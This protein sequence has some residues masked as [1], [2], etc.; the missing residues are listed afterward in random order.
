[1]TLKYTDLKES[2]FNLLELQNFIKSMDPEYIQSITSQKN[3]LDV[4]INK[5]YQH[6]EINLVFYPNKIIGFIAT[7]CNDLNTK[8]AFIT[9][10]CILNHY[11]RKGI[12]TKLIQNAEVQAKKCNMQSIS[13]EVS[14]HNLGAISFYKKH[15]FYEQKVSKTETILMTKRI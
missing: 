12:G 6:S 14:K 13:L 15:G 7:Y 11:R 5:L 4:Y 8:I 9:S 10:I 1:M 3:N 2:D